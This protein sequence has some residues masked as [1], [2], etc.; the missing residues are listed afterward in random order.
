VGFRSVPGQG[1]EFWIELPLHEAK[2]LRP[3]QSRSATPAEALSINTSGAR[4]TVVYIEDNPSNV[5]VMRGLLE[6]IERVSLLAVATAELGIEVVRG[7]RPDLVIMDINLPGMSGYEATRRLRAWPET[8]DIPVIALT[9][10]AMIGDHQRV[11]EAGFQRYL[12]KPVRID[13]LLQVFEELL[14]SAPNKAPLA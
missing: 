9:A 2:L 10:A 7:R 14:P 13:E 3:A 6:D 5:A 12:T 4:Y 11:S 1:S 8:R